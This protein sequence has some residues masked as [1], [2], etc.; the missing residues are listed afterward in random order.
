LSYSE[1]LTPD[2]ILDGHRALVVEDDP[3]NRDSMCHLLR[4]LGY[5]VGC[6]SSVAEAIAMLADSPDS[7]ILDLRLPDGSGLAVLRHI[8]DLQL[9]VDVAVVSGATD[10]DMLAEAALMRPDALF[11]KPADLTEVAAWLRATRARRLTAAA[12]G[13]VGRPDSGS[14]A[15]APGR[16]N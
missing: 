15:F 6:A 14:D 11:T 16:V 8:R 1:P 5:V 3:D 9:P 13:T 7:V 12:A 4:R 10:D 2:H